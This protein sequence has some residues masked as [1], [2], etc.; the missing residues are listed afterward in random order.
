M[1]GQGW[2]NVEAGQYLGTV[3][4]LSHKTDL[5]LLTKSEIFRSKLLGVFKHVENVFL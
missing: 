1:G 3:E 4:K 2:N 5:G